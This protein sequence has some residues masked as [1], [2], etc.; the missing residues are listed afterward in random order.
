LNDAHAA[1]LGEVWK[2][3]AAGYRDVIL[4]T[5]GTGVGGAILSEG[6]LLKGVIGRAGH[7][8]HI[9]INEGPDR[10]IVGTPGALE[11]AIGNCS[12]KERS[13]GKFDSTRQLVAAYE[14]GD[15]QATA[16]WMKSVRSLARAITSFINCIDP[17]LI[18][19]GGGIAKAG[20]A[21]FGPLNNFLDEME[22][23]P[24]GH[25]VRIVPAALGEWAGTFG[26]AWN[27]LKRDHTGSETE[28]GRF[29]LLG[30]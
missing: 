6:R 30:N 13:G 27:A 11:S 3:A 17:E 4:L 19:V 20:K 24:A 14:A 7:L 1:L 10:S 8:G 18:V 9:S 16:I 22:W 15:P 5:L 28:K 21:L 2:G 25:R 29:A 12:V 23:R 26:A